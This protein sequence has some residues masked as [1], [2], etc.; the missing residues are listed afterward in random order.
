MNPCLL[1]L[2]PARCGEVARFG[3]RAMLAGSLA[4]FLSATLAGMLL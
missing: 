1:L 3:L 4:S 2:A